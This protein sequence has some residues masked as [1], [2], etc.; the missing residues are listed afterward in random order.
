MY[1][2]EKSI[3]DGQREAQLGYPNAT[4]QKPNEPWS[5]YTDRQNSF[6]WTRQQQNK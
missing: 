3:Q 5:S 6:D 1:S 4:P 2:Y